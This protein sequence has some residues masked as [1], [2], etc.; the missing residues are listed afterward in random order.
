MVATYA[1]KRN[2]RYAYY[3]TRKDLARPSDPPSTRFSQGVLDSH[4]LRH[5]GDLLGDEH[6]LRR[7]SGVV[8]AGTLSQMFGT[9]GLLRSRLDRS[10]ERQAA[11]RDLIALIKVEAD[12][13]AITLKPAALGL[14]NGACWTWSIPLP[15]RRPFREAKLRIDAEGEAGLVDQQLVALLSDACEAQSLIL[16]A[17]DL[18]INQ[19]AKASGRCRKQLTK[20]FALSWLSPRIVESII[21]GTQPKRLTRTQLLQ[22]ELPIDWFEQEALFGLSA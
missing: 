5:V 20:L 17:P 22:A 12:H 4:V 15:S 3:E 6:A 21:A 13:L 19:V 16:A 10:S 7:L 9:A 18:S 14:A 8:E 11:L 1:T 2:R